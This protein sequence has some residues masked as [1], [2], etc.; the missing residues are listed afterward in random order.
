MKSDDIDW[1]ILRGSLIIFTLT[2]I[3]SG[4]LVYG[5]L[6]FRSQMQ[7][8]FNR[9]NA[10][11]QS[12]SSRYLAVDEEEKLIKNFLPRF[13]EL[14]NSGVIGNEQR[15]NWIEVLRDTG[16]EIRLPALSYQIDSQQVFTPGFP[17]NLGKYRLYSS[18]MT[19]NMSLMHEEDMFRILDKLGQEAKGIFSMVGCTIDPSGFV[20]SESANAA[21]VSARC[22]L[23]W[24][25][26]RL[27]D[28]KPIE[29]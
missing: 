2:V 4:S 16:D 27:A 6:Y 8:E 18:K 21:N 12:I 9:S 20:I 17:L 23:Q 26:I 29:V 15:L 13:V 24:Y 14:Y 11:F 7:L 10:A 25:T 5:G 3:V 19:L 28:G 1:K 22:D